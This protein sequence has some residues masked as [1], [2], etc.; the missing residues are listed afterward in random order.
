MKTETNLR[1][2]IPYNFTP[3]P[4]Q[5]DLFRAMDGRRDKPETRL[6]RALLRW[7]RRAGKDKGCFCYLIK[8]AYRVVGN[9]FYVFPTKEEARRV[10][11]ETRDKSGFRLLDHIPAEYIT[12]ISNQEMSIEL[13]NG[14]IIRILGFDKN[15]DSIRGVSCKGVVFSEFAFSLPDSYKNMIPSLR[16][17]DGWAIFNSTPNGRNHF[18]DLCQSNADSP[19]WF[20]S[21]IQT[22]DPTKPNYTGLVSP[23]DLSRIAKEDGLTP[24]DVEREYGASWESGLVGAYYADQIAAARLANRIGPNLYNEQLLVNTYF[25]IGIADTDV[26]WFGQKTGSTVTFIDYFEGNGLGTNDIARL[27]KEKG[28]RYDIHYLP[29][30]AGH[31]KKMQEVTTTADEL[32]ESFDNYSIGGFID[33][34]EKAHSLQTSILQVRK[35]FPYYRFDEN[36]CE[37]GLRHIESYHRKFDKKRKVYLPHPVHDEHCI[38][39]SC[40]VRVLSGWKPIKDIKAG[41]HVYGYDGTR[42]IPGLVTHHLPQGR[43]SKQLLDVRLDNGKVITCTYDH[44]FMLRD[45][46]FTQAQ[47]LE[48]NTSLMPFYESISGSYININL[49]DGSQAVEHRYVY[50]FLTNNVLDPE[51]H[52]D[53]IDGDHFNNDITNLQVLTKEEHCSKTFKGKTQ[54]QRTQ[55]DT[56]DYSR[57][58]YS[59]STV[60]KDCKECERE[61][62]GTYKDSYCSRACKLKW[63]RD[64]RILT[65]SQRLAKNKRARDL[66]R[67]ERNH[68]VRSVTANNQNLEVYDLTVDGIHNFVCEGV[69][70]HNSHAA[71]ALRME[72]E[73]GG[74]EDEIFR[75]QEGTEVKGQFDVWDF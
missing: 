62:A 26:I 55:V 58:I 2:S 33:V 44:K 39:G 73:G 46:S 66:Y 25:D 67:A 71:D 51:L 35:R 47:Y 20:V 9:Y 31:R 56:T 60:F 23:E 12:R 40:K 64:N 38:A 75:R 72:V 27:L 14:S 37:D 59:S 70:V 48:K 41:E 18:Y 1:P 34:V 22:T 30:D 53:H 24:E 42:L 74:A 32:Q 8:E 68:K 5:L 17:S 65:E 57:E 7:H 16:E 50:G 13:D 52:I 43:T 54:K 3:R 61:Y 69:V 11:W 45:G 19:R 6:K 10:I 63:R 4:Y 21:H 15:P 29:H 49:N 28:Y 36:T